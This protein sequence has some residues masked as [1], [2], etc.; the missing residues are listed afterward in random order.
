MLLEV[1]AT[2]CQQ[3]DG[4]QQIMNDH[5]FVHVQL[6]MTLAGSKADGHVVAHDLA[7]QHGQCFALCGV[8]FARHDRAARL[9]G[10]QFN[11][12]QPRARPGTQQTEV[13]G[14]LH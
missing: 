9:I 12:G 6:Q 14:Q 3:L 1:A 11:L 10:G 5:R 13:I 8:D 2:V 7:G 4:L